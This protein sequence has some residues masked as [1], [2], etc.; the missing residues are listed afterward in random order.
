MRKLTVVVAA[1]CLLLALPGTAAT[2]KPPCAPNLAKCPDEGCG[3]RIDPNLNRLK[4]I[5]PDDPAAKGTA[6]SWTLQ[7]IKELEDPEDFKPGGSRDELTDLGEGTKVRVVS[8]LLVAKPEG[9]ESC[10]CG[11]TDTPDTDNHLVLVSRVTLE[12]FPLDSGTA[13]EVFHQ[14][15]EESITG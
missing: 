13:K 8:Y 10:N 11:L 15:E 3:S 6:E 2:K 4:N 12:K 7:R 5:R 9:A 14:R 1:T